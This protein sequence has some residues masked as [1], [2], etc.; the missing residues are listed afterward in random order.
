MQ[1]PEIELGGPQAP[2]ALVQ[3]PERAGCEVV[4]SMTPADAVHG[5]A[6]P[7]SKPGLPSFWPEQPPPETAIRRKAASAS[8]CCFNAVMRRA[9]LSLITMA[10]SPLTC[11]VTSDMCSPRLNSPAPA[12]RCI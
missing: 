6:V 8:S 3:E 7:V 9:A 2:Q 1:L 11:V 10:R 4:L 12:R 5:E